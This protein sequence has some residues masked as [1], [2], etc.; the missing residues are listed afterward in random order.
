MFYAAYEDNEKEYWTYTVDAL[1][2]AIR[3]F[4]TDR[5]SF[6]RHQGFDFKSRRKLKAALTADYSFEIQSGSEKRAEIRLADALCG[7][8]GIAKYSQGQMADK[9]PPLPAWFIDLK[10]K[11][12]FRSDPRRASQPPGTA[13]PWGTTPGLRRSERS[14]IVVGARGTCQ[15]QHSR[16]TIRCP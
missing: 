16:T 5:R 8:L 12:S 13:R 2:R 1:A 7:Y 10:T 15:T 4:G 3:Y 9:Y 11:P 6:V 14:L